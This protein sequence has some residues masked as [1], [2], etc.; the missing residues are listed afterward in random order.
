[1][2][3]V[4]TKKDGETWREC[5]IRYASTYGLQAECLEEYDSAVKRLNKDEINEDKEAYAAWCALYEWDCLDYVR[6]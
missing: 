1:M 2:S 3:L 4:I 6:D 5:V